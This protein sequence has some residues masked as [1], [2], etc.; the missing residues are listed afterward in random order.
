MGAIG[1]VTWER[2][3]EWGI[4][5]TR[6]H[7]PNLVIYEISTGIQ[8]TALIRAYLNLSNMDLLPDIK[9]A[10]NRLLGKDIIVMGT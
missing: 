1:L 10:L 8:W 9:E 4:E 5:S 6:F 7:R 3:E 2:P